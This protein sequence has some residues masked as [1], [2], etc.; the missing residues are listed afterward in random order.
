MDTGIIVAVAQIATGFATLIVAIF[1][2][3]QLVMQRRQ[4]AIAHQDSLRELGFAA[5][6]RNEE[7]ILARLTDASLLESYMK[8][9]K[10]SDNPTEKETHQFFTYMRLSY[11]Q[12]INE[13]NLG[14]NDKNPE[15]FKGRLGTLM[16]S[17]GERQYYLTNGRI[18]IGTV[19][20]LPP[21]VDLGDVVY[22]ELHGRPIPSR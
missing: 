14:V 6:T 17:S 18:I 16:G 5:R 20:R 21:L 7:L 9:G 13:W 15:Y 3:A 19:F 2:A 22:E 8:V 1:L 4:L 12:M 11:L 10:G